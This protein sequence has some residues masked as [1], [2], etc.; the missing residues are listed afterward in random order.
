MILIEEAVE[1]FN[2]AGRPYGVNVR[3]WSRRSKQQQKVEHIEAQLSPLRLPLELRSFWN[4]WNPESAP[5]PCLDGF[6][7]LDAV[8]ERQ[9]LQRPVSPAILLPIARWNEGHIWIELATDSHPGGRIFRGGIDDS[10]VDLWAFGLSGLFDLLAMGFQ[11]DLIDTRQGGFDNSQFEA[12]ATR[13]VREHVSNVSPRRIEAIDR[14]QQ[15]DHWLAAEGLS[16][17]HFELRGPSHTVESF[18]EERQRNPKLRATLSGYFTNTICGGSISGCVGTLTDDSGTLQVF[19]PLVA[20]LSAAIGRDG[21]VEIDVFALE[22]APT[23]VNHSVIKR[24]IRRVTSRRTE[25]IGTEAVMRLSEQM[26]EL[27][28]TVV[29]TGLRSIK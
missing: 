1:R 17:A 26:R 9:H 24:E 6:L 8:L 14:S 19:V 22:H 10:H 4:V 29:V 5:W 20:D 3:P 23:E 7:S 11:Q 2:L 13:H 21:E 16:R 28:T 25:E 15:P 12:L 27:D 18:L